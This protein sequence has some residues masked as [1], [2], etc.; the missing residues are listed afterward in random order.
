MPARPAPPA[1]ATPAQGPDIAG[2]ADALALPLARLAMAHGL[3]CDA[4]VAAVER[5]FVVA[6]QDML[7]DSGLPAHRQVSRIATATGMGRREVARIVEAQQATPEASA[8]PPTWAREVFTRWVSDR[9]LRTARGQLKPLPRTGDHPSFDSLARSVTQ[10]V[11]PRSLL[12]ELCRLGVARHD[13][14]RDTVELQT[15]S[16]VP[17]GDQAHMIDLLRDNVGAHLLGAVDNVTGTASRP[18]HDQAILGDE[19]SAASIDLL[20]AHVDRL[21][22]QMLTET[23]KLME[24]CI[25]DDRAAGLPARQRMR[26]GLYTFEDEMPPTPRDT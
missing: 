15:D 21:W 9:R 8:P 16:F 1:T 25:E 14:E 19:L 18:H 5:A 11:H 17:H 10:H 6:A 20:R 22:Q 12:D 7:K 24:R 2:V 13:A 4:I 23:V 3:P 26:I